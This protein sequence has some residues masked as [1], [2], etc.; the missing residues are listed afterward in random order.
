MAKF[1]FNEQKIAKA[2]FRHQKSAYYI[3]N[4]QVSEIQGNI[5]NIKIN[6]KNYPFEFFPNENYA[7]VF[8]H[9]EEL[10]YVVDCGDGSYDF[11]TLDC[12]TLTM[13]LGFMPNEE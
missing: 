11:D 12:D 6:G 3:E 8:L 2:M 13:A 5:I 9:G 7:D 10:G 4:M 1:R